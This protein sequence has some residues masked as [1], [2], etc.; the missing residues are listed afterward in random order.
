MKDVEL[1]REFEEK[2]VYLKEQLVQELEE[3]QKLIEQERSSM[4]LT[5]DSLE[6]KPINTRY[7]TIAGCMR[8]EEHIYHEN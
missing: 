4:E 2:K 7:Q 5:G 8:F 3:K 1:F 6:L